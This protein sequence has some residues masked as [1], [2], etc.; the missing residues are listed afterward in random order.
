MNSK[1]KKD[2][3]NLSY[4][5]I[6]NGRIETSVPVAKKLKKK[7]ERLISKARKDTV[8]GR[9]YAARMLPADGV[10]KLFGSIGPANRERPGGYTRL[11][12]TQRRQGDS[13]EMCIL[14][15]IDV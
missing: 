14:E 1:A 2:L 5:L 12:R 9:R 15:I 3:R 4:H 8:A 11:L 7:V 13:R 6:K 10:Q